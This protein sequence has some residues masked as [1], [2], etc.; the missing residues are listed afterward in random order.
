MPVTKDLPL[1]GAAVPIAPVSEQNPSQ[2]MVS[3]KEPA[4]MLI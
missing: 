1:A 4:E 3:A 2:E